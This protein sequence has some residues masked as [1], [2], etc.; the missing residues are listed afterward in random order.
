MEA[1]SGVP[2]IKAGIYAGILDQQRA[3]RLYKSNR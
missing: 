3:Y 1:K 2:E